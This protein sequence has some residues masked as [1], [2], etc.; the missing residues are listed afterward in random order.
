MNEYLK[1]KLKARH[2]DEKS[3]VDTYTT[4]AAEAKE[5]G[6]DKLAY[7]LTQIAHEEKTHAEFIEEYLKEYE[8][9]KEWR[10]N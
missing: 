8:K 5:Q 10:K 1:A 4:L 7:Y 6:C 9:Q 2:A 3:D